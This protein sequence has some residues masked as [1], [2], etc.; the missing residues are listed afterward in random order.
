MFEC[1][2]NRHAETMDYV[3]N[4]VLAAAARLR[5]SFRQHSVGKEVAQILIMGRIE[6]SVTSA[7]RGSM[8]E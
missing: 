2:P 8:S 7:V 4:G 1:N 3:A 5:A 6:I